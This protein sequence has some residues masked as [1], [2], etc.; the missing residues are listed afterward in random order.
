ME[1]QCI[2]QGYQRFVLVMTLEKDKRFLCVWLVFSSTVSNFCRFV[3]GFAVCH[4]QIKEK[5]TQQIIAVAEHEFSN[6]EG[7]FNFTSI[8]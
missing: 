5:W 7:I 3:N 1:V 8:V 4:K 2:H 6:I